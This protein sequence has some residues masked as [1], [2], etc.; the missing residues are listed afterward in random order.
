MALDNA[1][2]TRLW[3]TRYRKQLEDT[4]F[5]NK[6]LNEFGDPEEMFG[7]MQIHVWMK[8]VQNFDASKVT[9]SGDLERSFNAFFTTILG[10]FLAN[11]A[12]HQKTGPQQWEKNKRSLDAPI[13]K[14]DEEGA[15][16]LEVLENAKDGSD[17][18][19]M[20]DLQRVLHAL[21]P[22]LE[23]PLEYII[24]NGE[25][26]DISQVMND[27]RAKGDAGEA[28]FQDPTTRK[29]WT[30]TRLLNAL[31]EEAEFVEFI[32]SYAPGLDLPE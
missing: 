2:A 15:N 28:S 3:N 8:A 21:P 31:M 13:K 24:Q 9:Y 22:E 16:L 10:Q 11:Q 18:D 19:L 20:G 6:Y 1:T 26:G 25:R 17:P 32:T 30:R 4:A 14:D 27:I 7:D 5:K 29:G 12:A 23:A